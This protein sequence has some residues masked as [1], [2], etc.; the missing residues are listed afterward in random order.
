MPQ[1]RLGDPGD[2]D[3]RPVDGHAVGAV[4]AELVELADDPGAHRRVGEALGE[5]A[6]AARDRPAR[7]ERGQHRHARQVRVGVQAD[8]EALVQALVDELQQFRAP[9]GVHLVVHGGVRQVQGAARAAGDRD[10]LGVALE[11]PGAVAA[12]VRPEEAA[13][14][15]DHFAQCDQLGGVGVHAGRVAQARRQAHRA[16][17]E[18]VRHERAHGL[19]LGRGGRAVVPAHGEHPDGAVGD[20]V[21]GVRRGPLVDPVEVLADRAP[22]EVHVVRAAVPGGDGLPHLRRGRL[23]D[24]RVAE[25]VLSEHLQ[26]AALAELGEVVVVG[27]DRQLGVGVHVDEAGR[28]H[29]A[30]RVDAPPPVQAVADGGD[31]AALDGDVGAEPVGAG[32]VDDLG[33]ADDE[34]RLGH[35]WPFVRVRS[36]RPRSPARRSPPAFPLWGARR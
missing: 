23:V 35:A 8:V 19:E 12:L 14:S 34:V 20:E 21:G 15:G 18:A 28:A 33:A 9:P 27:Q 24:R 30:A 32:A 17:F 10:H 1:P 5:R 25:P 13:V 4:G 11:R 7:Q 26:G 29:Q 22:G 2:L 16:R 3:P 6:V 31:A 36:V